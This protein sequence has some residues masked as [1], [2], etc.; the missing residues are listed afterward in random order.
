MKFIFRFLLVNVLIFSFIACQKKK[1]KRVVY[2]ENHAVLV[3]VTTVN[4]KT[5]MKTIDFS[6]TVFSKNSANIAPSVSGNIAKVLVKEGDYVHKNQLVA[7]MD[8]PQYFQAKAQFES[9][10]KSFE[11]MSDLKEK[12]SIPLESFDKVEAGYKAAKA[13]YEFMAK[14]YEIRSPIS[15]FVVKKYKNSGELYSMMAMGPGGP[16]ILRV[17]NTNFMRVKFDVSDR[18]ISKLKIGQKALVFVDSFP[19][20]SFVGKLVYISKEADLL[21]GKFSCELL[22]KN[23]KNE[24]KS[25]QF[26]RISLVLKE[27]NGVLVIPKD[28]FLMDK[29]AVFVVKNN[30]AKRKNVVVGLKTKKELEVVSGLNANDVVIVNGNVGLLDNS[31]VILKK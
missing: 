9:A 2:K 12:G 24:L 19:N 1:E 6:G 10:K 22:V 14:N 7:I 3:S 27:K 8:N 20:K 18:D 16:A 4:K 15:G 23:P 17:V 28:A 21:S 25:N 31:K 29:D 26:A 11:R 30:V 13:G 5:L